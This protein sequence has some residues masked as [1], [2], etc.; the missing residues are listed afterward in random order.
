MIIGPELEQLIQKLGRLPG[1]GPRSARRMALALLNQRDKLM[2][3]LGEAILA[4]AQK[5]NTCAECGNLDTI[6]PCSLCRDTSRNKQLLCVI[7]HVSDLWA[8]ERS[9]AFQGVYAV[10]GGTLSAINGHG[11]EEL[12]IP[13]LLARIERHN[14]TEVILALNATVDGQTTVH[15]LTE[16]LTSRHIQVTKLAQGVPMGGEIH[17]LDEATLS[18]AL[19]A[20]R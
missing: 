13:A 4:A 20:R 6:N 19:K 1:L 2:I 7:E 11:P 8:I 9:R 15:Y 17:Y 16:K 12:K 10:L 5:I 18:A 3:P 14:I